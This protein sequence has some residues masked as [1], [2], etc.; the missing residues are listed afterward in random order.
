MSVEG[1]Q[2]NIEKPKTTSAAATNRFTAP[3]PP[4]GGN[5][6]TASLGYNL[7]DCMSDVAVIDVSSF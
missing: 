3:P 2:E 5:I 6:T 7:L 4:T 1:S